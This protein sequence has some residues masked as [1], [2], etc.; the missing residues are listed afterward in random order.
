MNDPSVPQPVFLSLVSCQVMGMDSGNIGSIEVLSRKLEETLSPDAVTR[1]SAEKYLESLETTPNYGVLLLTLIGNEG[2]AMITRTSGSVYFKNF[3]R[4]NWVQEEGGDE[5]TKKSTLSETDRTAIRSLVVN[6]MLTSPEQIQ[7]QLSD[8]ITVIGKQDFPKKWP[9]LLE[10]LVQ[11]MSSSHG[12]FRVINGVLQTAHCLFKKY[13]HEFKSQALWTEIKFVLDHFAK[14]FTELFLQTFQLAKVHA[15]DKEALKIIFGSLVLSAKIF[16][17][18]NVQDLPEFFEDNMGVWMQ[19]FLELLSIQNSL[20]N[21]ELDEDP[22]LVEQLK[23]QVCDNISLYASKYGE[24]FQLYLGGFVDSVW[25]LL[26]ATGRQVKFDLLVSNAIKF[27]TTASDRPQNKAL[28]EVPGLLDSLCE[29]IIVPNMELRDSDMEMF[30]DN[31]EEFIRRD[32]EG[33]DI[34]TR[35]RAACDLIRSLSRY[36]E[37]RIIGVLGNFIQSMLE[38]YKSNPTSNWKAK[39][40]AIYLVISMAVKGSTARLGTTSTSELVNLI[41]LFDMCIRPELERPDVNELPVLKAD[42]LKYVV[43]FRNQIPKQQLVMLLPHFIRHLDAES[44]V[45]HTYAANAIEKMLSLQDIQHLVVSTGAASSCVGPLLQSL[46]ALLSRQTSAE[47][48]YVMK[49][50]M[51]SVHV[52]KAECTPF[53]PLIVTHLVAKV[54]LVA[55]NPTKPFFNHYLFETLAVCIGISCPASLGDFEAT[56]F[57]IFTDILVSDTPDFIPYVFQILAL[58]LEYHEAGR[59]PEAYISL[60]QPILSPTLWETPA[61]IQPVVYF[62]T[63]LISRAN[64]S[65]EAAGKVIPILGVFQKLVASKNNDHHGFKILHSLV[66]YSDPTIMSSLLKE[67]L[68]VL[69]QRSMTSKTVKFTKELVLFLSLLAHKYKPEALY[70]VIE[71]IQKDMFAM[72]V[73]RIF[74]QELVKISGNLERKIVITGVTAILCDLPVMFQPPLVVHWAPLVHALV[75]LIQTPDQTQLDDEEEDVFSSAHVSAQLVFV[76]R[77]QNDPCQEIADP[78]VHMSRKLGS[79]PQIKEK[80]AILGPEKLDYVVKCLSCTGL[81]L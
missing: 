74:I 11:R 62:L 73:D 30:E 6:M 70:N 32:M 67:I 44:A 61:N 71:S 24:E 16:F 23:S 40:T 75:T 20:L 10:E 8:A 34:D 60:L 21:T 7:R 63:T 57:P 5:G 3:V 54:K 37:S 25:N 39:D 78:V 36:F 1:K 19:T 28:F 49:A 55:K 64:H 17:S 22:G 52:M 4:K 45:T 31:P 33:S 47:N 77:K 69:F 9:S 38:T 42:A 41:E 43:T 14:P 56:L 65:I 80:L 15:S 13:R 59:V 48:E 26:M 81:V 51:R 29:K 58:L 46:F 76:K 79:V 68:I 2:V 50:I 72:V 53:I 27:L 35:R 66:M 18:L 12:D